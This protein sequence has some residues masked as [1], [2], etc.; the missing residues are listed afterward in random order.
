M[1]L[2]GIVCGAELRLKPRE[3]DPS[4]LGEH[5]YMP[6]R[7]L[8]RRSWAK[9]QGE[10]HL[11]F[12]PHASRPQRDGVSQHSKRSRDAPSRRG[13]RSQALV[14]RGLPVVCKYFLAWCGAPPE[15]AGFGVRR[16]NAALCGWWALR[17]ARSGHGRAFK[18]FAAAAGCP[19]GR[20]CGGRR[21]RGRGAAHGGA[22]SGQRRRGSETGGKP[23]SGRR[24]GDAARRARVSSDSD[25]PRRGK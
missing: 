17:G 3:K 10:A 4:A 21:A 18:K 6:P 11:K 19:A 24:R 23:G 2:A 7:S 9:A 16:A 5:S 22:P 20:L 12:K 8:Q 13:R 25:G 15:A 14:S 1:R